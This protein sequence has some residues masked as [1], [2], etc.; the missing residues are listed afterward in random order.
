MVRHHKQTTHQTT[1]GPLVLNVGIPCFVERTAVQI[2]AYG[3]CDYQCAC[4]GSCIILC[5]FTVPV[6]VFGLT[7]TIQLCP[8]V[9]TLEGWVFT[10]VVCLV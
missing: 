4:V 10:L 2:S 7:A 6:V 3:V 5:P 9:T 1:Q 8:I